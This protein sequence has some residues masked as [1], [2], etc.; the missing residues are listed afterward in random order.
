MIILT[1][2]YRT[3][4]GMRDKVLE[5]AAPCVEATRKEKGNIEYALYKSVEDPDGIL[6]FEKWENAECLKAHGQTEH[7]VAFGEARKP[8]IE[9]ESFKLGMFPV[10][11]QK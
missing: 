4:P 7:Y 9:Q 10:A 2:N 3:K 5:L 11:D 1:A 8:R 6:C